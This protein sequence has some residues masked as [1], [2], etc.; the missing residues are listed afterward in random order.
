MWD[1]LL[2]SHGPSARESS[3]AM[4]RGR[5][6]NHSAVFKAKL[7]VD[8]IRGEKTLAGLAKLHDV[9]PDQITDSKQQLPKGAA[10]VVVDRP[11]ARHG[12]CHVRQFIGSDARGGS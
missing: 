7:A 2:R 12:D 6:R 3:S 8:A 5:R 10:G 4:T 1:T 9:H 11:A